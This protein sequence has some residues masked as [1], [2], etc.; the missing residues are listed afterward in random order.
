M[1]L[2]EL[3]ETRSDHRRNAHTTA[4]KSRPGAKSSFVAVIR[5]VIC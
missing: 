4:L 3:V 1:F 5:A 2:I